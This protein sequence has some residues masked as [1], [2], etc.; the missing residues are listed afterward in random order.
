MDKFCHPTC[1]TIEILHFN[2]KKRSPD[3]TT[4]QP[5][6]CLEHLWRCS[7]AETLYRPNGLVLAPSQVVGNEISE[8][9]TVPPRQSMACIG[10][11]HGPLLVTNLLGVG[12]APSTFT[13]SGVDMVDGQCIQIRIEL[14]RFYIARIVRKWQGWH[15]SVHEGSPEP[16]SKC[17][18][19]PK[20]SRILYINTSSSYEIAACLLQW[21]PFLRHHQSSKLYWL[22][23]P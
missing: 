2:E 5:P 8:P 22:C 14:H 3:G 12:P 10:N 23:C 9:S 11:S 7:T 19:H 20:Q 17:I 16:S 6:M 18:C 1:L 15:Q 13:Y 21:F 4:H